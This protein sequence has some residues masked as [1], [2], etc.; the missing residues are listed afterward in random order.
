MNKSF[1][2]ISLFLGV[3]LIFTCST[4]GEYPKKDLL[5]ILESAENFFVYIEKGKYET[6][7]KLLSEKSQM[8][9][10]NDVY[11]SSRKVRQNF[12]K[13]E[14]INDF[15]N[16]GIMFNSYWSAFAGNFDSGIV[17]RD[18]LWEIG[19]IKQDNAEI[20]ITHKKSEHPARLRMFRENNTWKVG[21]VETFWTRK[22]R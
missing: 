3:L 14:V 12:K 11:K 7:W 9:I 16:R 6:A 15:K 21:L 13:E 20:V 10:I 1:I 2:T 18:S 22:Y 5:S 8:T 19:Y 17:L 4:Y